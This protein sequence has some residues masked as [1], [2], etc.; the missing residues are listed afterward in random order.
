LK[1]AIALL[2]GPGQVN[3]AV[4]LATIARN[5]WIEVK[6]AD[7]GLRIRLGVR[8]RVDHQLG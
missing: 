6:R 4:A 2:G 8:G 3:P 7:E 1:P 5:K